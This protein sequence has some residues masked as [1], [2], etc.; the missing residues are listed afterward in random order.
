MNPLEQIYAVGL[1]KSFFVQNC[2]VENSKK[3]NIEVFNNKNQYKIKSP[4]FACILI[5]CL[6]ASTK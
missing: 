2:L 1:T 3:S 6:V 5:S 4:N